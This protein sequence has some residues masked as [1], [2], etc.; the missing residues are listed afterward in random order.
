LVTVEDVV[1]V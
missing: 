1:L